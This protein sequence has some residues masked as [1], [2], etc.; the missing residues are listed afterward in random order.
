MSRIGK[1][2]VPIPSGVQI[3]VDAGTIE[4]KGSKGSLTQ[5]IPEGITV[6]VA[7]EQVTV[8]RS[9]DEGKYRALHGLTRALLANA[10]TGVSE[11]FSKQLDIVGVGYKAEMR[12]PKEIVFSLGYSHPVVYSVPDGIDVDYDG[13]A[14]RLTVTGID[15]QRVGQ[16]AAEIRG[17]RPPEPYKGKG[18]RYADER[19]LRKEAKKK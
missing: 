19:I 14:N 6:D 7:A 3:T 8:T 4:V 15:K 2:P 17:H 13:K 1:N 11:G 9:S 16:V 12:S 10:V 18:V 5:S